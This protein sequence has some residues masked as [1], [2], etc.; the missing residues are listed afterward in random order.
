MGIPITSNAF[1]ACTPDGW[2]LPSHRVRHRKVA[3]IRVCLSTQALPSPDQGPDTF[4]WE[5]PGS[6]TDDFSAALT[7]DH[8]RLK[9][10]KLPWTRS[11]WFKGSIPKHAFTFWVAHLDRLP[12]RHRLV[13][14]GIPVP[15]TCL[16][17]NQC[18]ETRDHLF[19]QCEYSKAIWDKLF[20]RLGTPQLRINDWS[21]FINWLQ[22][23][24]GNC[25]FTIKHLSA[26][27]TIYLLWK[28]RNS[29]L[30]AG[31]SLPHSVLFKQLDR[32]IRDIALA[33]R[34][35]KQFQSILSTWFRYE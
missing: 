20:I 21:A 31:N 10:P 26:Q 14:W 1:A 6:A 22:N 18:T 35:R 8:L 32:C 9:T 24:M 29:R 25:L 5:I 16:L 28:E 34:N 11:V 7:W 15:E 17:C 2:R 33:R 4:S 23:A 12:V 3:E 27:A 13:T 30:H 19:L